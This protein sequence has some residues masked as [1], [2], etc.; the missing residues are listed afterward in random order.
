MLPGFRILFATTILAISILVFGLGAAALLRAAHEE[1]ASLP[2][3]RLAQQPPLTPQVPRPEITPVLAM[4]RI[5]APG[6][7]PLPE[8][9]P[10]EVALPKLAPP[11]PAARQDAAAAAPAETA[12]PDSGSA[13]KDADK[14]SASAPVTEQVATL[15][16]QASIDAPAKPDAPVE[17]ANGPDVNTPDIK[18]S[19]SKILEPARPASAELKA[20]ELKSSELKSAEL[21][22]SDVKPSPPK[23]PVTEASEPLSTVASIERSTEATATE[24]MPVARKTRRLNARAI[25]QRREAARA[26]AEERAKAEQLR[27]Q[28]SAFPL[29]GG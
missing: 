7:K 14:A 10:R 4:L 20:S 2:S 13:V 9:L 21:K 5:E 26:R 22:S 29:F 15:N 25:A 16:V 23:A 8:T 27:Q 11:Q 28:K 24:P 1:F 17:E 12:T 18:A 3:W 6:T 19:D